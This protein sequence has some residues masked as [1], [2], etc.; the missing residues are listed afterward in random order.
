MKTVLFIL[1]VLLAPLAHG[2]Q[3][4]ATTAVVNPVPALPSELSGSWHT[5]DNMYSQAWKITKIN[6]AD[7]SGLL[8]W[9]STRSNCSMFNVPAKVEYDGSI[10]IISAIDNEGKHMRC[11]TKFLAELKRNEA[12]EFGGKVESNISGSRYQYS[13]TTIR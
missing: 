11:T 2:Q 3:M 4:V 12:N 1:A 10:L 6:Q 9:Y 7:G 13:L 5:P 8:T